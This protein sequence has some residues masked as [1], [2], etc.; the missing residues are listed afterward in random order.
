[1]AILLKGETYLNTTEAAAFSGRSRNTVYC[2]HK[3]WGWQSYNFGANILFKQSDIENWLE[4]QIN[5][6]ESCPV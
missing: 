1:M 3:V 2:K 6:S 4:L 5:K